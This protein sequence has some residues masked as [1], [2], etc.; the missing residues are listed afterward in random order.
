MAIDTNWDAVIKGPDP[1]VRDPF[2][3]GWFW[4]G[5]ST[6]SSSARI[7]DRSLD[8]FKACGRSAR[9]A[10]AWDGFS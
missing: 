8:G 9:T 5:W 1:T 3:G 2:F 4:G 6:G 10:R 7:N